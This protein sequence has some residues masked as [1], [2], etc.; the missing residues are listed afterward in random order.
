MN[1]SFYVGALGASN[2]TEKMSVIAN[3]MANVNNHGYKPKT[4]SFLE[5]VSD[6]L[7]DPAETVTDLQ[8]GAGLKV[9]QTSTSFDPTGFS[10]T[11]SPLDYA[12]SKA[13]AFFMV[14]D[15][16][17]GDISYTRNGQF[18]RAESEDGFY[19]MTASG[20]YVLDQNQEPI[21]LEVA[22]I[23]K[24]IAEMEEGYEPEDEEIDEEEDDED[25][26]EVSIYTF[27]NP[28]RLRS[29]GDNEYVPID[30]GAEPILVEN[31]SLTQGYLESSGTDMAKEMVRLIECQRA[32]S[33]ALRMV[34]VSDEIEGTINTL[35]G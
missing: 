3:N 4:V 20:K 8:S 30:A 6:N 18:H 17:T 13:N 31:P 22:D 23:E 9:Q 11:G 15:P 33:Y 7:K 24:M 21:L 25:K 2:C 16:R 28:S 26:P 19:L 14:Q 10:F 5:L 27:A 1:K 32:F 35:R 34:T 29:I 12:I